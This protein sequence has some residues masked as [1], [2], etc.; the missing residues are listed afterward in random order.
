LDCSQRHGDRG[1]RWVNHRDAKLLFERPTMARHSRAAHDHRLGAV[2]V[3]Q[4][5]SDLDHAAERPFA[6]RRLSDR[7]F[8]RP[9]TGEPVVSPIW[10]RYRVCLAI[11]RWLM[12]ITP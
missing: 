2:L 9:L 1:L 4:L 6:A 3:P 5:S 11:E 10:K 7:H 12:A 8:E